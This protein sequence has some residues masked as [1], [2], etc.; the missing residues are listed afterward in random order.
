MIRRPPRSTLFPYTTLFR[1]GYGPSKTTPLVSWMIRILPSEPRAESPPDDAVFVEREQRVREILHDVALHAEGGA[2]DL[3]RGA[4]NV[5]LTRRQLS[6]PA[7]GNH[8]HGVAHRRSLL[9]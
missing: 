3:H 9:A 2:S 1:A 5:G 6:A 8:R 7:P 4:V